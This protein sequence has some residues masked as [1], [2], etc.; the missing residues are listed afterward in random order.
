MCLMAAKTDK[1]CIVNML[2]YAG[3]CGV[4]VRVYALRIVS[5]DKSLRCINTF[6]VIIILTL[7]LCH[8]YNNY[9][10]LFA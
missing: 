9:N 8:S 3:A 5:P 7:V 1:L 4:C 2:V 10:G 6:V